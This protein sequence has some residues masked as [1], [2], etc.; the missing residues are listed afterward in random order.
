MPGQSRWVTTE[1][2]ARAGQCRARPASR[3]RSGHRDGTPGRRQPEGHRDESRSRR[4]RRLGLRVGCHGGFYEPLGHGPGRRRR[5][6]SGPA[7]Q[8]PA[9]SEALRG[10]A[11]PL[12]VARSRRRR[13]SGPRPRRP[14]VRDCLGPDSSH[15]QV[16]TR[17]VF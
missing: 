3:G 17:L 8:V 16:T 7:W 11:A 12:A 10:P 14:G 1:S 6:Q 9:D 5:G 13:A 15:V 4:L 2:V